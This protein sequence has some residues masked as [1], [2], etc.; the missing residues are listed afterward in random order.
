VWQDS[1]AGIKLKAK[2]SFL[3]MGSAKEIAAPTEKTVFEED[4]TDADRGKASALSAGLCNQGNTCYLNSAVQCLRNV[5]GLGDKLSELKA[6]NAGGAG[7]GGGGAA[8]AAP[9][10]ERLA[11]Y[12][13][14]GQKFA[15]E[16]VIGSR[17]CWG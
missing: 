11:R 5:D 2:M 12:P 8:G 14:F 1:W 13:F 3:L 4:F 17:K 16:D 6:A 10:F 7:A 15:R 9:Q